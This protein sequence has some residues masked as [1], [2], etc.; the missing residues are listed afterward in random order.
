MLLRRKSQKT[1]SLCL[2]EIALEGNPSHTP[3]PPTAPGIGDSHTWRNAKLSCQNAKTDR[4]NEPPE[5]GGGGNF[6]ITQQ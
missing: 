6:Q 5:W 1:N 4:Q 3:P 2:G